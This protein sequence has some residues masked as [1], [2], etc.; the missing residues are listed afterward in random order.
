MKKLVFI[1]LAAITVG[2]CS[3]VD[4]ATVNKMASEMCGA[5]NLYSPEDPMSGI[6]SHSKYTEII[7]NKE[8]FGMVTEAQLLVALEEHCPEGALLFKEKYVKK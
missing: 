5:M 8:E 4:E 3:G 2:A 6:E 1:L 7:E